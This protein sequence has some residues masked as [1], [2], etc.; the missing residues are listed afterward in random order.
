MINCKNCGANMH[1]DP[2]TQKLQCEYCGNLEEVASRQAGIVSTERDM[3]DTKEFTCPQ[4]GATILSDANTAGTFCSYCGTSV[5]F[6]ERAVQMKAP[7]Y[8]IPF[9]KTQD[10]AEKIYNN[11]IK[12]SLFA[13]NYMKMDEDKSKLRGIYMP[14]WVYETERTTPVI[15]TGQKSHRSGDYIIHENYRFTTPVRAHSNGAS[16]D[17][18]SAFSDDLS[19]AIA[20][21]TFNQSQDFASGYLSGFYVDTADVDAS[22][23]DYQ[24]KEVIAANIIQTMGKKT[25]LNAYGAMPTMENVSDGVKVD[26]AEMSYFPVWFYATER[27]GKVSYAVINGQT[28]K[29][30]ADIPID[31]GKYLLGALILSLPIMLIMNLIF[32]PRP[33][34][35]AFATIIGAVIT[36][37]IA[38]SQLNQLYTR[39]NYLDDR[40]LRFARNQVMPEQMSST[41]VKKKSPSKVKVVT[42]T[43]KIWSL[44]MPIGMVLI[45]LGGESGAVG[46]A[47]FGAATFMVGIVGTIVSSLMPG[48]SIPVSKTSTKGKSYVFRQPFKEKIKVLIKP[49]LVAA[50]ALLLL[51]INPYIDLVYY[52]CVFVL[53][54]GLLFC[55]KDIIDTHNKLTRRLPRQF[56][57]RGGDEGEMFN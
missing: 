3:Y 51:I 8:I 49:M 34:I 10:E 55:F 1:F 45:A 15:S 38:N 41:Q 5:F 57:K 35:L 30:A 12:K 23:Y 19:Q 21:Y 28:G 43:S 50:F 39:M 53:M 24:A 32:T 14:Y 11:L 7:T 4:C 2:A 13:P 54:T 6:K 31:Y 47:L 9:Q 36:Y 52:I 33:Q 16:F 44:C 22:V 40:G 56:N 26:K 27:K 25:N 17:A 42:A 29:V 46:V 48:G 37:I 20:P 18:S